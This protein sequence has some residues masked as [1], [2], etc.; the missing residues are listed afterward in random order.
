MAKNGKLLLI[1]EKPSLMRELQATYQANKKDIPYEID[2]MALAGHVCQ[3]ANPREYDQWNKKWGEL[4]VCLPMVPEKWDVK[5]MES[6][7]D[8]VK[9][10]KDKVKNGGYTGLICATDA[11]REGNLIFTLLENVLRSKLPVY[12]LWV[13]DLTEKEIKKA[14]LNM[15]DFH[16]DEMQ[17][18]LTKAAVLR[19]QFDWLIGMNYTV[20][21]T[22]RSGSLMKI[23]RVKTPTLKLVYDNSKAID[24][25]V[26]K[27]TYGVQSTSNNGILGV[28]QNEDGDLFFEKKTDAEA[29][30]KD[31][32]T[33][34][35]VTDMEKKTVKTNAPS[36]FKLSDLQTYANKSYGYSADETLEILQSLYEKKILSYPRCDCRFISTEAMNDIQPV[37]DSLDVFSEFK[38]FLSKIHK[39]EIEDVKK[40]TKYTND[41]EV[42]KNSHTALIPT[43]ETIDLS[44]L[45]EKEKSI[46][47]T[48][49]ARLISIFLPAMVEEKTVIRFD[50]NGHPFKANFSRIEDPGYMA[51]YKKHAETGASIPQVKKGDTLVITSNEIHEKVSTPPTRLTEGTLIAAMENISKTIDDK[52]LKEVMKEAKGIG[53]PSSRGAIISSLLEDG[54]MESK[55]GKKAKALYITEKGTDYI[56]NLLS[57]DI[58][59]PELTAVWEDKLK[60]VERG[61]L[62]DQMFYKEMLQFTS[63][64]MDAIRQTKMTNTSYHPAG[65]DNKHVSIGKCPKCG[66]DM[67]ETKIAFSCPGYKA[68]PP[69]KFSIFKENP[70]LKTGKKQITASMAKKLLKGESVTVKGLVSKAGRKYS[71]DISL[72]TSGDYGKL[73]L[74]FN[75]KENKS[76]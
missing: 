1:A 55:G 7:K 9:N 50:N 11:D 36:L 15:V 4:Y 12:R 46:L 69:C 5:I 51:L 68:D 52:A 14:F 26:P 21:A 54:Y 57:F 17:D 72:D 3:Y 16:K 42:N 70:I 63:Q 75:N 73:N 2:F 48:V 71:A 31:L 39:K 64:S 66:R 19:S 43:G 53:T 33:K 28:L 22:V 18:H 59:S 44:K 41:K 38:P 65:Q 62:S 76:K 27:T 61:E 8:L 37:L 40:N 32:K 67:I 29:V 30:V 13:H 10:I 6:K 20:A 35:T 24:S 49:G 74:E 58:V 23:G 60:Q 34:A 56:E 25:F 45:N 47:R